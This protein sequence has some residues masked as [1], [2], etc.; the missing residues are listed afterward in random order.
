MPLSIVKTPGFLADAELQF[1]WY[2]DEAGEEVACRY[3][4]ALDETLGRISRQ[5]ELVPL[6]RFRAPRLNGLRSWLV[7]KPFHSHIVFY[8]V[9]GDVIEI[10]RVMHGA[11]DLPR[12]LRQPPG[13]ED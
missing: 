11:R 1:E 5:P 10:F 6:R 2:M 4:V 8:R 3:L 7:A 12:R 9:V 13:S